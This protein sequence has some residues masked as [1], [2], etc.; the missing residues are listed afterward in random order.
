M[1]EFIEKQFKSIINKSKFIDNWFWNRYSINPY[2]GCLFGCIYCDARSEKYH[3]PEDFE[4]KIIIKQNVTEML[5]K[6]ISGARTFL[7]DVVAMGGVTDCYQG[8]EKKYQNTRQ[9]L[10][11]LRKHQYPV[12]LLTKSTLVL[13]DLALLEDIAQTSWCTV[14]VTITTAN[15]EIAK[16][17]DN[18][19]PSPEKRFSVIQE[20]KSAAPSVQTG[21]LLIP[22][23]PYLADSDEDLEKMILSAKAAGADYVL[24]GGGMTLR[25]QQGLWFLNKLQ[26][27][28]P[29]LIPEYE[30]LY[31]FTYRPDHYGGTDAP[32]GDYLLDRHQKLFQLCQKYKMPWRVKRYIPLDFRKTNYRIA[33]IL[34]NDAYQKQMLNHPWKDQFWA[35]QNIQ[36]LAEPIEAIAEGGQLSQI[37][38]VQGKAK[39]RVEDL[40]HKIQN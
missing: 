37:R 38:N 40:L 19:S 29:A 11:I 26:E 35:A 18:R 16:F 25:D 4:N 5:D 1:P 22:L 27:K 9:C 24:F 21:I 14:S 31:Q 3:M 17:L 32:S 20:I 15:R 33:E 39:T 7:P 28:Y 10:E 8:A 2:N 12:H 6:R 36:N 13:R 23:I 30:K 34:L